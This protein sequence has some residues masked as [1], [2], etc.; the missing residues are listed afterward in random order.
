MAMP[1]PLDKAA[2]KAVRSALSSIADTEPLL[3]L[4]EEAGFNVAEERAR[5]E[6]YKGLATQILAVYEPIILKLNRTEQ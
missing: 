3:K 1:L 6:H 4:A 2:M 5:L